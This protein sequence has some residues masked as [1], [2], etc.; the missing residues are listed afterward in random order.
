MC[1]SDLLP[2]P[3]QSDK[4]PVVIPV[5]LALFGEN[6]QKIKLVSADARE[7]EL[8]RGV[9]ELTTASR[10]ITFTQVPSRPAPSLLRGFSAPVRLEP[11]PDSADLER[12]LACDDDPFN[13]WQAAQT[14]ALRAIF[15]RVAAAQAG[16]D[17][18]STRLN[19]SH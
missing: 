7:D 3:G 5:A 15:A 16:A 13:R 9:F 14:L 11:A 12:L 6:G 2:T 19:S 8:Q 17:R 4:K 10:T 18:K 1:S